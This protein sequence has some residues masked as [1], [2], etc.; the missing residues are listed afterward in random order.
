MHL[1]SAVKM[2]AINQVAIMA[3][4]CDARECIALL[5][6]SSSAVT[7]TSSSRTYTTEHLF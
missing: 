1:V 7:S 5:T 2:G 4:Y 3:T 6:I